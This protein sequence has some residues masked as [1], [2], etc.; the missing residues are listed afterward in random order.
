M[1]Q[2]NDTKKLVKEL[3]ERE[4]QSLI[5]IKGSQELIEQNRRLTKR[6][7]GILARASELAAALGRT[8]DQT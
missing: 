3:D 8:N 6:S 1:L 2:I 4:R 5:R 7:R